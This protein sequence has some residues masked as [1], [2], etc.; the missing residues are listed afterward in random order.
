MLF[1]FRRTDFHSRYFLCEKTGPSGGR[2]ATYRTRSRDEA[3]RTPLEGRRQE[4]RKPA[5]GLCPSPAFLGDV[6][7]RLV[8]SHVK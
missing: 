6:G 7:E 8:S 5:S 4:G 2:R 1:S 3:L